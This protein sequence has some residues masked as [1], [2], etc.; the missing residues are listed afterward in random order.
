MGA[1]DARFARL[2]YFGG[3]SLMRIWVFFGCRDF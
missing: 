2:Q 3:D 1:C